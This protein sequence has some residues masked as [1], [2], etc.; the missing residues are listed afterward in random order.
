MDTKGEPNMISKLN[1]NI[2][3][4]TIFYHYKSDINFPRSCGSISMTL[5]AIFEDSNLKELY[6]I[7]YVRGHFR[8]DYEEEY[9][10]CEVGL[11]E[12]YDRLSDLNN[13]DCHDC[14]CDY[15]TAHS[16]IEFKDKI[17]KKVTIIDFTNIQFEENFPDYHSDIVESNYSLTKNE[18]FEYIYNR[19]SF[20][21]SSTHKNF[22][23]YIPSTEILSGKYIL[24]KTR[25]LLKNNEDS[26]LTLILKDLGYKLSV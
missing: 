4:D 13:F 9:C 12:T 16:W 6:D 26:A 20:I 3:K 21:V 18:I 11:Y 17:T 22:N 5:T 23:K 8:N 24:D 2:L 7:S 14:S 10:Y 1:L 19:S 15:M 25:S